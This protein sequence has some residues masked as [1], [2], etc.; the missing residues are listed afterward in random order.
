[1][2]TTTLSEGSVV[3]AGVQWADVIVSPDAVVPTV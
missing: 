2:S 3:P 1:M